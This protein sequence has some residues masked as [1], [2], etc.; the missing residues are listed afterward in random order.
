MSFALTQ[1]GQ[2]SV[3]VHDIDRAVAFYRDTLGMKHLFSAGKMAFFQCGEIRLMLAIPEKPEFD[4]PSSILYYKVPDID[5]AAASLSATGVR[6]ESKPH[7]VARMP[8]HE[9]WMAFFR[10]SE[11]NLLS[12][13]CEKPLPS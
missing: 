11:Q 4:Y 8:T 9:L 3:N 12:L 6:F 2:I 10:D 1:I 13:M 7:L 5:G